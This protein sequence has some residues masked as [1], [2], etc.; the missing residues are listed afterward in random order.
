[1]KKNILSILILFAFCFSFTAC[2]EKSGQSNILSNSANTSS[3]MSVD[4][5]SNDNKTN[6]DEDTSF[7]LGIDDQPFF[8]SRSGLNVSNGSGDYAFFDNTLYFYDYIAKT[9]VVVCDRP[10]CKHI[11]NVDDGESDCNAFFSQNKYYYD[12][13]FAYYD[14]CIYLLGQGSESRDSV[15]LY[16]I[17]KDGAIRE[18]IC[19]LFSTSD[20]NNIGVFTIHRGYAF[21]SLNLNEGTQLFRMNINDDESI[22]KVFESNK[23][24]SYI[25]R[26]AGVGD[27][28][29]FSY[30][31]SEDENYEDWNGFISRLNIESNETE[32]LISTRNCYTVMDNKIFYFNSDKLCSS[33]LDGKAVTELADIPDDSWLIVGDTKYLYL[34]NWDKEGVNPKDYKVFVM[35]V[36]G[37]IIDTISISD[38]EFFRGG[39]RENMYIETTDRKLKAFDKSQIATG[40]YEWKTIYAISADGKV[41]LNG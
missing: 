9:T 16:K 2:S 31:Y 27:Y 18:E 41:V 3:D 13:G 14:G 33:T 29:Y 20:W 40:Q 36:D 30:S 39:S 38:C 25:A 19:T 10:D 34:T 1:M 37:R 23:L 8:I 22:E 7:T 28:L 11:T 35:S 15:S 32:N 21:W 17:S 6:A 12:K 4:N 24:G 26:F 5:N